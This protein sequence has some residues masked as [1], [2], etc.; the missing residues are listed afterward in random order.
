MGGWFLS[1]FPRAI[2]SSSFSRL[3]LILLPYFFFVVVAISYFSVLNSNRN[4]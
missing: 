3:L 1:L 2:N 4:W